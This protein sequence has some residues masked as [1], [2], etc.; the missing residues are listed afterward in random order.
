[1]VPRRVVIC[2]L[3]A[4]VVL[5]TPTPASA[6]VRAS[7]VAVDYRARVF[8]LRP[9]LRAALAARVYKTDQALGLTVR[10]GHTVVVLGYTGEPFV[11]IGDDGVAVNASSPTAGAVG[12][13]RSTSGRGWRLQ[14]GRRTV[15]WHDARV[16][17]LPP[18]LDRGRWSVPVVVDGRRLRL[19]GEIWR[20]HV[21][22]PWRWLAFGVPFVAVALWLVIRR[23][24][25]LRP[26]AVAFGVA[27]AA[28]TIA[29]AA[30][31]ALAATASGG[32]WAE[33]ANE[34]VFALVGLGVVA[35]GSADARP[36]AGGALGLLALWVGL[37]KVPVFLHG[38]VLAA[39]PA[40]PTRLLVAF[41]IS[42][43]AAATVAGL[44]VLF[45]VLERSDELP[46]PAGRLG[47]PSS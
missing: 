28:G 12:L 37:S 42:V 16:R 44:G 41:T 14:A 36:I 22:S 4:F 13:L 34:L 11:R 38:V 19:E 7:A 10:R 46:A 32:R 23:R 26:A 3:A 25:S 35:R 9:E 33:A 8:P 15:V 43:G 47:R 27:A 21:P 2:S 39:L 18:E 24:T 17:G 29:T 40:T 5:V 30:T 31:F 45:D 20:I 1:M 6:H